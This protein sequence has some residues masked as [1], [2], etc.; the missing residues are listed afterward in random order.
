MYFFLFVI[1][2]FILPLVSNLRFSYFL[3][4][5]NFCVCLHCCLSFIPF[6]LAS[7]VILS[8]L[9]CHG[10][11]QIDCYSISLQSIYEIS[12][13]KGINRGRRE[14]R[15]SGG[16]RASGKEK[17]KKKIRG[18]GETEEKN[19]RRNRGRSGEQ[20]T[21]IRSKK[22]RMRLMRRKRAVWGRG[23]RKEGQEDE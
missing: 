16:A 3:S 4:Y 5:N 20:K 11:E 7:F 21:R 23:A 17:I 10:C 18:W 12:E 6:L 2:F 19:G 22:M 15:R 1:F 9:D 13:G 8:Y 14:R